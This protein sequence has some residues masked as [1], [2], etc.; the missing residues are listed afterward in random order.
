MRGQTLV[1]I[2]ASRA[3]AERTRDRLRAAG[4]PDA[5]I[6][7]SAE[8][9]STAGA[10]ETVAPDNSIAPRAHGEG[11]FLDWLFGSDVS[12]NDRTWYASTL[13]EGRTA[14]SVYLRDDANRQRVEDVLDQSDPI[15]IDDDG[16]GAASGTGTGTVGQTAA[17]GASADLSPSSRR[18]T[19]EAGV[20]AGARSDMASRTAEAD[21]RAGAQASTSPTTEGEQVIPVAKEEIEIGKR[22]VE[23]RRRIRV[24]V[25]E[26]PVEEQVTLRD[27]RVSVERRPV[28]GDRAVAAADALQEREIEVTERREEAV[29]E[30]TARAVEE[31]VI[32]KEAS[33]RVETVRDTV[34]ETKVDVDREG[35]GAAGLDRGEVAGID[36]AAAGSKP[37]ATLEGE[38][39]RD[40]RS[41]GERIGDK[42]HDLKEDAKDAVRPTRTS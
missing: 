9:S 33:E 32:H 21:L 11:G 24:H 34:R 28:S 8:D 16:L 1:A 12:E 13:N 39:V 20:T 42:A 22:A 25:V 40:D 4:I 38:S 2:Y 31:V 26:R 6:R 35:T 15:D 10:S 19:D 29:V 27:E 7:L 17:T 36:R 14:V 3:D 18:L 30:K 37:G 41:L 23:R 5:D